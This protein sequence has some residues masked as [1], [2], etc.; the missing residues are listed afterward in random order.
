MDGNNVAWADSSVR[1]LVNGRQVTAAARAELVR[2]LSKAQLQ[3]LE[4]V[5]VFDGRRPPG[6]KLDQPNV[7]VLYSELESADTVIARECTLHDVVATRDRGLKDATLPGGARLWSVERLLQ[8]LHPRWLGA[9]AQPV[10]SK[11]SAPAV[12]LQAFPQCADCM[13]REKDDWV[14]LCEEDTLL[15]RARNY[16]QHW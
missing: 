3:G 14:R 5:V 16:R 11:P 1:R 4:V 10:E 12:A 9:A 6:E 8:A 13:W 2:L 7:R 15:G